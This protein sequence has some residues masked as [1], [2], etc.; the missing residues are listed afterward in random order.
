MKA[1]KLILLATLVG[2]AVFAAAACSQ[3]PEAATPEPTF[4]PIGGAIEGAVTEPDGKPLAGMRVGIV[5]GTVPFPEIAPE[6]DEQGRYR[7][8]SVPPGVF[9]VAVHDRNG[10]RV[11]LES[12]EVTAGQTSTQ[13][14]VTQTPSS[15]SG[16]VAVDVET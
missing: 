2:I 4:A 14:F 11:G 7:I 13:D 16:E 12:V 9:D 8:G 15:T 10:N 5:N 6:T 1:R 3:N